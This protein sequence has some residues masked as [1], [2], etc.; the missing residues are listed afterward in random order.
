VLGANAVSAVPELIRIYEQDSSPLCKSSAASALGH[1]GRGAH[2]ALPALIA[3]FND[4]NSQVRFDAVSAVMRIGGE[5][6]GV[7]PALASALSDSSVNVRW[8]A[9]VGLSMFGGRARALVP[10]ILKMLNDPGMVGSES[11][12]SQVAT[13][14]WRIAPERVGKPLVVEEATPIIGEG[15]TTATVLILFG[16]KRLPDLGRELGRGFSAYRRVAQDEASEAGPSL[17]GIYGKPAAQVLTAD[18]QVAELYY[19]AAFHGASESRRTLEPL[20][21]LI[22]RIRRRM[23]IFLARFRTP[24]Q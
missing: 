8:N 22:N 13:A 21:R 9:L 17:G 1:I 5:P 23:M 15:V 20:G 19:P 14:L 4:T 11:I 7:I 24:T 10:E 6:G 18:N 2:L 12:T 3:R 16:A